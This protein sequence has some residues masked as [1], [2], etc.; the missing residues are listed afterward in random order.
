MIITK[1]LK[2]KTEEIV[3]SPCITSP[4]R[5]TSGF[6]KIKCEKCDYFKKPNICF[7]NEVICKINQK[8]QISDAY[9]YRTLKCVK[10]G[11]NI[12]IVSTCS[13]LRPGEMCRCTEC[14]FPHTYVENNKGDHVFAVPIEVE[15]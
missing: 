1:E 12:D 6:N 5:S 15:L 8:S 9:Y 14:D 4:V 13:A 10:C 3:M 2:I 7:Y 11:H